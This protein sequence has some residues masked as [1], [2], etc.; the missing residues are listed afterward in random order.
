MPNNSGRGLILNKSNGLEYREGG[1]MMISLDAEHEQEASLGG[2]SALSFTL[3]SN[4]VV[5]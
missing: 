3:L 4:G 2:G 5:D 1:M